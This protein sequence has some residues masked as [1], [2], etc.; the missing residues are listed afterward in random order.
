MASTTTATAST[1]TCSIA[2]TSATTCPGKPRRR[3]CA[4]RWSRVG[5]PL[6][7]DR[8]AARVQRTP[9]LCGATSPRQ[10]R[11]RARSGCSATPGRT[12]A[13]SH[14][15]AQARQLAG[16]REL[17]HVE[18][19]V[20]ADDVHHGVDQREVGESL[21]EVAEVAAGL[22]LDLLGVELE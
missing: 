7:W 20:G 3:R 13:A 22:G 11:R 15:G 10:R 21:R 2:V 14:S 4:A 17:T 1:T 16:A 19:E 8:G 18:L 6:P 5:P 12:A 9:P